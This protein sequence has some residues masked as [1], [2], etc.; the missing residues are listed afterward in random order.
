MASGPTL[1]KKDLPAVD[2]KFAQGLG[3]NEEEWDKIL[4]ALGRDPNEVECSI[5][6]ALWSENYSQKSCQSFLKTL[7]RQGDTVVRVP[8]ARV[9]A[10][11]IGDGDVLVFRVFENNMSAH[12]E[13]TEGAKAAGAQVIDEMLTLGAKPVACVNLMRLGEL[14]VIETQLRLRELFSGLATFS[15]AAGVPMLGGD[16]FFHASYDR[17]MILNCGALGVVRKDALLSPESHDFGCPILMIGA[18]TGSDGLPKKH[19]AEFDEETRSWT[20]QGVYADPVMIGRMYEGISAALRAGVLLDVVDIEVG[21]I[22]TACFE[23]AKR[24]GTGLRF[25]L[26]RV[27][28]RSADMAPKDI[29]LS[30]SLHRAL[31]VVAKGRHRAVSDI[32]ERYG[33]KATLVGEMLDT[34]DVIVSWHHHEVAS[35]PYSFAREGLIEK[36]FELSKFP[37]MLRKQNFREQQGSSKQGRTKTGK[38]DEWTML[39]DAPMLQQQAKEEGIFELPAQ[40]DDAWVDLLADPNL[41]SKHLLFEQFDHLLRGNTILRAGSDAAV[42]RLDTQEASGTSTEKL[43]LGKSKKG[44]AV[45]IDANVLYLKVDPY[46]GTVQTVAEGMRN[47]A[48]VGAKPVAIA[49]CMNFGNPNLHKDISNLSEALRGLGDA[50]RAWE[51]PVLSDAVSLFNG[52]EQ[53]P[54]LGTPSVMTIGVMSDVMKSCSSFFKKSGD[55]VLL[56]GTTKNELGCSEYGYYCHH[57]VAGAVPDIDF[58]WEKKVCELVRSLVEEGVLQ[59]AHDVS[60]G[61]IALSLVECSVSGPKALGASLTLDQTLPVDEFR[62][63]A[64]LF[65]ETSGRFVVSC[66]PEQESAVR[67][68]CEAV[69]VSI[70]GVGEVGGKFIRVEGAVECSVPVATAKRIWRDGLNH[71]FGLESRDD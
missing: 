47:L 34:D 71:V 8:G 26:E 44:L 67:A 17:S 25:D 1:K 43:K 10:V 62:A 54:V 49:H 20:K 36:E 4:E 40:L 9:G 30:E 41:C 55:R 45:T 46:L 56:L 7:S 28:V 48:A 2:F 63:D 18:A 58:E 6:S 5:F 38:G 27:R 51:I 68:K 65:S 66:D 13:P 19:V 3:L 24:A 50:C 29:L 16:I 60:S 11:D 37:P 53:S 12:F 14:S 70:T 31:A 69:G 23:L 35:V 64:L 33:L 21:G 15:N 61:G 59:S 39:R 52:T 32:L 57:A 22:A 42:I